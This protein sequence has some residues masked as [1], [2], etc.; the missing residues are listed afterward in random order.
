VVFIASLNGFCSHS[1]GDPFPSMTDA[2]ITIHS[3]VHKLI[4][5]W[6]YS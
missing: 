3:C 1:A 6:I 2:A 4:A 5:M